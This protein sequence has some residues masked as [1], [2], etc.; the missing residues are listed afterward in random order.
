M[1]GAP[2]VRRMRPDDLD[3]TL[4][5]IG[6]VA[7]ERRWIR[8]EPG[9][10]QE[11]YLNRWRKMMYDESAVLLV[12]EVDDRVIG[13]ADLHPDKQHG[14]LLA[15]F[16][17]EPFRGRGVGKALLNVVLTWARGRALPRISLHVFPHNERAIRLYRSAGFVDRSRNAR[18]ITRQTGEVWDTILMSK[19]L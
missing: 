14:H 17:A 15:M 9:F 16:V 8:A 19:T 3:D 2:H 7:A 5:L 18:D 4:A 12:A 11:R 13:F 6:A 1:L 10:D